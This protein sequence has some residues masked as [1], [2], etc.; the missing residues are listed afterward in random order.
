[1][2]EDGGAPKLAIPV[3]SAF[4]I[5]MTS[6]LAKKTIDMTFFIDHLVFFKFRYDFPFINHSKRNYVNASVQQ[7]YV[8]NL[9]NRSIS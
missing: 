5:D 3:K 7:S 4:R 6:K 8:C 2:V 1:P 9:I